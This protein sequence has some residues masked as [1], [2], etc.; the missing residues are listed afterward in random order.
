MSVVGKRHG[1]PLSEFVADITPWS[2]SVR[3]Q[4]ARQVGSVG[5]VAVRTGPY[6]SVISIPAGVS[7]TLFSSWM[8]AL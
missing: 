2:S 4:A 6:V 1:C 5:N 8:S 3:V 7:T